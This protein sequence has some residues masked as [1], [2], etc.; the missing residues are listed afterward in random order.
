MAVSP[1]SNVNF[2]NQNS[3]VGSI[4]QAN[5]QVKLDFQA[6]ISLQEMQDKENEVQEVRPTEETP[7]TNED[8]EDNECEDKEH[9]E[10][11]KEELDETSKEECLARLYNN[12][13]RDIKLFEKLINDYFEKQ[14]KFS[15]K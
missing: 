11:N 2:I 7:K 8:K 12:Q 1:I 4:Q 3:Q 10:D 9:C 14:K 15:E 13:D 6:M 5:N